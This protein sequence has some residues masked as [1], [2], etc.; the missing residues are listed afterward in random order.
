[1]LVVLFALVGAAASCAVLTS[2]Q[3]AEPW[4]P[5]LVTRTTGGPTRS[6]AI[7][8]TP[9]ASTGIGAARTGTPR[10]NPTRVSTPPPLAATRTPRATVAPVQPIPTTPAPAQIA[11]PTLDPHLAVITEADIQQAIASGATSQGGLTTEG[12]T[13][14]FTGGKARIT[15]ARLAYGPVQV[16]NLDLV[17]RLVARNGRLQLE[18]E[19]VTPSGLIT[20][21]IPAVANQA[22]AQYTSQ[23]YIEEVKM[24]EGRLE[25]RTR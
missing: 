1:M 4:T 24:L 23:W 22:L 14:R 6:G 3:A 13:V 5:A 2:R 10:A 16:Q 7:L 12:L 11:R 18:V 17:G 9:A 15:A 21:L 8:P 20:A 25:I 19:S